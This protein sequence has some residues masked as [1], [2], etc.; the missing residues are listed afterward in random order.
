MFCTHECRLH[1][2]YTHYAYVV[3][4]IVAFG[5]IVTWLPFSVTNVYLANQCVADFLV[6]SVS[7]ILRVS[8]LKCKF[9]SL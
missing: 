2:K 6:V 4:N 7:P 1:F 3:G 9:C 8:N 5:S